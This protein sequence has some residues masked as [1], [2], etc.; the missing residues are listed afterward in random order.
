MWPACILTILKEYKIEYSIA[1]LRE[2]AGTDKQGTNIYGIL[3]GLEYFNLNGRAV[4]ISD[5]KFIIP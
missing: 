4:K 1:R 2:I 5:K 3:K